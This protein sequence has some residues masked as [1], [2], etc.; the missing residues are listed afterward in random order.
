MR[1]LVVTNMF[2]TPE[3]PAFGRFVRDQVDALRRIGGLE[4]E[5]HVISGG[6]AGAYA[7]AAWAARQRYR[8]A[9]FD[10]VHAHF[11]LS[12]WPALAVPGRVHAVT[13]HGTDVSHPRS[14]AIT[15]PA[16]RR[17]DVVAAVS[18]DLAGRVP[19]WAVRHGRVRVLPCGVDLGRFHRIDRAEAREALGLDP[20]GPYLLFP[21]DPGRPE[22][23]YDLAA[24]LAA[25]L[26]TRL[27]TLGTVDPDRVPLYVNAA[28]AVL[29]TSDREGF[30]LAVLEALACDVPVLA[31]PHGVAPEALGG[32]EGALCAPFDLEVWEAALRV[33]VGSSDPRVEGRRVAEGY[34]ADAMAQRVA[35]TWG[36]ALGEVQQ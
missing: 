36:E 12:A 8:D 6:S 28:N 26:G 15:L 5:V 24:A 25:R 20:S 27:L 14:R 35:D 2:P 31:T 30:G 7:R 3:R 16:L 1:A 29:V 18:Q 17:L 13:L 21:A 19:A 34:S 11:G 9:R 33:H 22:K 4:L 10:V 23:R 32:V